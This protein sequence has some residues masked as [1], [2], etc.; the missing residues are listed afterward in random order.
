MNDTSLTIIVPSFRE[1]VSSNTFVSVTKLVSAL[2]AQGIP[3]SVE[4]MQS[5]DISLLRSIGTT[6]WYDAY[7]TSHLLWVDDD[8]GFEAALILD[9]LSINQ[10]LVSAL[11]PLRSEPRGWNGAPLP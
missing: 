10:P 4:T 6:I 8:M 7:V 2:Q 1:M 5:A 3:A 11:C 9:M